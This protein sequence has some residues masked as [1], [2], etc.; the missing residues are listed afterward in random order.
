M[1]LC[2]IAL[3][4]YSWHAYRLQRTPASFTETV[5]LYLPPGAGARGMAAKLEEAGVIESSAA[6]LWVAMLEGDA[7]AFKAGE[8]AF[9][10]GAT[11]QDA[12]EKLVRGEVYVR[13]L[14]IPEGLRTSEILALL[15][16]AEAMTGS[17]PQ[18]IPEGALM[19]D[20][21]HY[22][23]G[24]DR[25]AL[26]ARMRKAMRE[27]LADEWEKRDPALPLATPQ[28]ALTLAS[29]VEKETG[30]P[31]E[32]GRVAAVFINRLRLGMKL[33]TDPTVIYAI[34]R[35]KGPL[36]RALAG[37][38]LAYASPYNTYLHEGLPPGPIANPGRDA[39]RAAL[40]PPVTD[41]LYFVATGT[42]N[43]GHL[44]AKTLEEHNENVRKY[45]AALAQKP[46][47]RQP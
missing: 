41:D 24:D 10:P 31:E 47:V 11:P 27:F 33:Q 30:L 21:Y 34:E 44:F 42:G 25:A 43:G 6:F 9:Q 13:K 35:E 37:S 23:Y 20:T 5:T 16:A 3:G 17:P 45:R 28:E 32:R 12:M 38:D 4:A 19:P 36:G 29:I 22:H 18:D 14:T 1:I 2:A 40:H 7:R 39:I 26:A 46:T 15:A 8:Y